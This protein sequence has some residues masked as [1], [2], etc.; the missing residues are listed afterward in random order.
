MT[1]LKATQDKSKIHII[2][3]TAA[4]TINYPITSRCSVELD[5][6]KCTL[7]KDDKIYTFTLTNIDTENPVTISKITI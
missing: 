2:L 6:V 4:Y 5:N 7:N 1:L 3:T